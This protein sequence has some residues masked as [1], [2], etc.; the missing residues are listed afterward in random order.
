MVRVIPTSTPQRLTPLSVSAPL[1]VDGA[2]VTATATGA[3][4]EIV[5]A[6]DG[7]GTDEGD[8]GEVDTLS[9]CAAIDAFFLA[10][11]DSIVGRSH[12]VSFCLA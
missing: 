1:D 11:R 2:S 7:V 4:G 10:L 5:G 6:G 3:S 9:T 8:G 12:W